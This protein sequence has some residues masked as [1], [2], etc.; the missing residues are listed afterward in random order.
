MR[1]RKAPCKDHAVV[2]MNCKGFLMRISSTHRHRQVDHST[3]T[4]TLRERLAGWLETEWI[5][6]RNVRRNSGNNSIFKRNVRVKTYSFDTVLIS[7]SMQTAPPSPCTGNLLQFSIDGHLTPNC[8]SMSRQESFTCISISF[9]AF[10]CLNEPSRTHYDS[11]SP[12]SAG[13]PSTLVCK[14]SR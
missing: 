13:S 11:S 4:T 6:L 2:V 3:R 5:F 9:H 10:K 1:L 14:R 8:C 12:A 7:G